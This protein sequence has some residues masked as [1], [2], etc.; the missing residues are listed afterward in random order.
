MPAVAVAIRSRKVTPHDPVL[1]SLAGL[2]EGDRAGGDN[3]HAHEAG[4]DARRVFRS[5]RDAAVEDAIRKDQQRHDET[6]VDRQ[7]ERIERRLPGPRD[8]EHRQRDRNDERKPEEGRPPGKAP[9]TVPPVPLP[10]HLRHGTHGSNSSRL[11]ANQ[12]RPAGPLVSDREN[13][14]GRYYRNPS[15]TRITAP[16]PP[17]EFSG[18]E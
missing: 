1:I 8:D 5:A 15:E 3:H 10:E 11:T 17:R 6:P 18:V 2:Q 16:R 7:D 14:G 12:G 4:S 13:N 9:L